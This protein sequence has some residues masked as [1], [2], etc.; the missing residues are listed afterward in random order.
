MQPVRLLLRM[1]FSASNCPP[2]EADCCALRSRPPD[3]IPFPQNLSIKAPCTAIYSNSSP[4]SGLP[5]RAA[6]SLIYCLTVCGISPAANY[7][8]FLSSSVLS[9]PCA[10]NRKPFSKKVLSLPPA[11]IS[12]TTPD[13][14]II[15]LHK[16]ISF[17]PL[18]PEII[19]IRLQSLRSSWTAYTLPRRIQ[20]RL[21]SP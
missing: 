8:F 2:A 10:Q 19:I 4:V 14:R 16:Y 13:N 7:A 1:D 17:L 15:L 5:V 18:I 12:S 11:R 20:G 3:I 21:S 6:T 9:A